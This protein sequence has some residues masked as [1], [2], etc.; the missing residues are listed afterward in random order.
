MPDPYRSNHPEQDRAA[1]K[2]RI[3]PRQIS[4]ENVIRK[5]LCRQG[6]AVTLP[7][8]RVP[9]RRR[10][11]GKSGVRG[12]AAL[13]EDV[14]VQPKVQLAMIMS[15]RREEPVREDPARKGKRQ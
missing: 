11:G 2:N 15:G 3:E 9:H 12:A 5:T 7:G 14:V 10:D 1:G 13:R 6:A 4:I 8:A